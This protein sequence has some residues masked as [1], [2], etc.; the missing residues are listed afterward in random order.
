MKICLQVIK[1]TAIFYVW[2]FE[3]LLFLESVTLLKFDTPGTWEDLVGPWVPTGQCYFR[4]G[5]LNWGSWICFISSLDSFVAGVCRSCGNYCT[6]SSISVWTLVTS[7]EG[8]ITYQFDGNWLKENYCTLKYMISCCC[9][10]VQHVS[11]CYKVF[12]IL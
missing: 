2:P 6:F 11:R 12:I 7:V 1:F 9:N 4:N 8:V 3:M 10:F 5:P